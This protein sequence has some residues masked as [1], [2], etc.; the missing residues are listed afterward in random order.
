[1]LQA[2][3]T[4]HRRSKGLLG[5][6]ENYRRLTRI[7]TPVRTKVSVAELFTDLKKLFGRVY[8]FRNARIRFIFICR[9]CTDRASGLSTY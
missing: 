7:P 8:S 3:Q 1:M 4:I 6:V 5:F 9:P 2:M